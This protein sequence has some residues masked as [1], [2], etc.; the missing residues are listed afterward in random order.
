MA[1]SRQSYGLETRA[2]HS[3]EVP[4]A[5]AVP[6]HQAAT[7]HGSYSRDGHNP[8]V[9]AFEEKVR[10]LEGGESAVATASGMSAISQVL[11]T[12]LKSG[13]RLVAHRTMYSGV[14]HLLRDLLPRFGFEVV[15]IDMTDLDLLAD[16][17]RTPTRVVYFEPIANP[18][19]DVIDA[20]RAIGAA[21]EAGSTVLIDNTFLTPCLFRPL[22]FGADVVV[23]SA[24]KYLCGHGDTLGGVAS[25]SCPALGERVRRTRHYFGGILSPANAFLLLRGVKTLPFRIEKHC[26]NAMRIAE[27]LARHPRVS[28]VYYPGLPSS[29]RHDVAASYL[30]RF[31]GMLGFETA[32][33]L[34]WE[35]VRSGL[36][37]IK[38]WVS[39]GDLTTLMTQRGP[40][41]VRLSVGLEDP[42]DIIPE[43][44]GM[45]AGS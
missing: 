10:L 8:T 4:W 45:L 30:E 35:A 39:L 25:T 5:S 38:P 15:Q 3:G 34:D 1:N 37:L 20:P 33:D 31:G 26:E 43:L 28:Q 23:H 18:Y 7:V 36:S 24:S 13:D 40:R 14:Q 41:R 29:P 16:A 27:F 19:I 2:I 21:R 11:M 6:I 32:F 42:A 9:E 44:S 17:L 12:L 22:D